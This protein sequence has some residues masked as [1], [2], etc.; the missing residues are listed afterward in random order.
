LR[1]RPKCARRRCQN[2]CFRLTKFFLLYCVS[3]TR[4]TRTTLLHTGK[5][6][7]SPTPTAPDPEHERQE[8]EHYASHREKLLKTQQIETEE[9]LKLRIQAAS[10]ALHGSRLVGL[11]SLTI[12]IMAFVSSYNAYFSLSRFLVTDVVGNG[13]SKGTDGA[14]SGGEGAV[15]PQL[16]P[17]PQNT[18]QQK[19]VLSKAM[20][21]N[22]NSTS[23]VINLT[24]AEDIMTRRAIEGW[25]DSRSVSI[26]LFGLRVSVD[27]API[28]G[29][30]ALLIVASWFLLAIRRENHTIGFL[31]RDTTFPTIYSEASDRN[32][33]EIDKSNPERVAIM[34]KVFNSIVSHLVFTPFRYS[35]APLDDLRNR[36]PTRDSQG[37][38]SAGLFARWFFTLAR[39]V[40]VYMPFIASC[41]IYLFSL[42]SA[43]LPSPFR[44][45]SQSPISVSQMVFS[46]VMAVSIFC[47]PTNIVLFAICRRAWAFE[48]A[49]GRIIR[50]YYNELK[51][52]VN[53]IK[54]GNQRT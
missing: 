52:G 27:D 5:L 40:L 25:V 42:V 54:L 38:D 22:P 21:P 31:L 44:P 18:D 4:Y 34:W 48:K 32:Y 53:A 17:V 26:S 37:N 3:N 39:G 10:D 2:A 9:S 41:S 20:T 28:L 1:H 6:M 47:I 19:D 8:R 45:G 43:F 36:N 23:R 49:T 14:I 24:N 33:S 46:L 11:V 12:S 29:T 51:T 15:Q 50:D 16:V 13:G 7:S 30:L 35:L